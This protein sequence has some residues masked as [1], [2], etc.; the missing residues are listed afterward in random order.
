MPNPDNCPH[1]REWR[2]CPICAERIDRDRALLL[3]EP[4]RQE[5]QCPKCGRLHWKLADNP[6][7]SI[8]KGAKE[9]G[10]G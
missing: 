3:G 10:N 7:A 5:C 9:D 8:R 1:G 2:D 4:A 6:P